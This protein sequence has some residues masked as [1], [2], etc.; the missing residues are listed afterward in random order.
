MQEI[1]EDSLMEDATTIIKTLDILRPKFTQEEIISYENIKS[2]IEC[3]VEYGLT[4]DYEDI[5]CNGV[6]SIFKLVV[7]WFSIGAKK[8]EKSQ[9]S[10]KNFSSLLHLISF[11]FDIIVKGMVLEGRPSKQLC[12]E[13]HDN[14]SIDAFRI[15]HGSSYYMKCTPSL[16]LPYESLHRI[17]IIQ[18]SKGW[19]ETHKNLIIFRR[20]RVSKVLSKNM[21]RFDDPKHISNIVRMMG[22]PLVFSSYY[23]IRGLTSVGKS[24]SAK[25]FKISIPEKVTI[26]LESGEPVMSLH[27]NPSD[28]KVSFRLLRDTS[29]NEFA[30]KVLFYLHGGAFVGPKARGFDNVFLKYW[31]SKFPGLSIV[32]VDYALAPEFPFPHGFLDIINTYLWVTSDDDLVKTTLGFLPQEIIVGGD[33]AGGN[34][35]ASLAVALNELRIMNPSNVSLMPKGMLLFFPKITLEPSSGYPSVLM[36][37]TDSFLNTFVLLSVARAYVPL[38]RFDDNGNW[39]VVTDIG[40]VPL[41]W[42]GTKEYDLIASSPL[43][44]PINYDKFDDLSDIEIQVMG[45]EFDPLLDEAVDICRKW[46]G[47]TNLHIIRG[48]NHGGFIY[49]YFSRVGKE[50]AKTGAKMIASIL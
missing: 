15:I 6:R 3:I 28:R 42:S 1:R 31:C 24:S 26:S 44:S 46:K 19:A 14:Y 36:S 33:S 12:Q 37:M 11:W 30:G 45:C 9:K 43:L 17:F 38:K 2:K 13:I 21:P 25:T 5:Q 27:D 16:A 18:S 48:C 29:S 8:Y 41:H 10:R 39:N 40:S 32:S 7:T 50:S 20:K 47:K 34:F 22:H 23:C 35:V 4:L 49:N